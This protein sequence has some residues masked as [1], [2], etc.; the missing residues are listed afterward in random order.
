MVKA[1]PC[2]ASVVRALKRTFH[3]KHPSQVG[4]LNLITALGRIAS[5]DL[6]RIWCA[7]PRDPF[8]RSWG[9]HTHVGDRGLAIGALALGARRSVPGATSSSDAVAPFPDAVAPFLVRSVS[10]ETFGRR[11]MHGKRMMALAGGAPVQPFVRITPTAGGSAAF[12]TAPK[13]FRRPPNEAVMKD[14]WPFPSAVVRVMR[15]LGLN[16]PPGWRDVTSCGG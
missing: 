9:W 12:R 3:V 15:A 5:M 8:R 14:E 6:G 11:L 1:L 7:A 4:Q 13:Y 2:A 16:P 10:R